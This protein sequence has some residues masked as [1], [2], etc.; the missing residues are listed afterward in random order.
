MRIELASGHVGLEHKERLKARV[1][2]RLGSIV[3]HICNSLDKPLAASDLSRIAAMSQSHFSKLFNLSTGLAQHQFVLE[4]RIHRAKELLAEGNEEI[5]DIALAFG[6]ENRAH[7]TTVFGNFVRVTSRQFRRSSR[8]SGEAFR[9][10]R[11]VV[12]CC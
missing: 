10:S 2:G 11:S 5:V 8:N 3:E 1:T 9:P 6:F 12:E 7:F 4:E